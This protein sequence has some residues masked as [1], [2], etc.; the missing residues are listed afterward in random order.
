MPSVVN[1]VTPEG[2]TVAVPQEDL[3]AALRRGFRHEGGAD[4]GGRQMAA[5]ADA[6][7]G[8]LAGGVLGG[9]NAGLAGFARGATLGMSDVVARDLWTDAETLNA[10]REAHP[11]ISVTSEIAGNIAPALASGGLGAAGAAARATPAGY[12][13]GLGTRIAASGAEGSAARA[14]GTAAAGAAVEGSAQNLGSYISDVALGNKELSAEGALAAAGTGGLLGGAAGGFLAAGERGFIAAKKLIPKHVATEQAVRKAAGD[15]DGQLSQAFAAGDDAAAEGARQL[16]VYRLQN[17]DLDMAAQAKLQEQKLAKAQADAAAAEAKAALHQ[18]KL[19]TQAELDKIRLE[20]AKTPRTSR[21]GK[22]AKAAP[23]ESVADLPTARDYVSTGEVRVPPPP[24]GAPVD[25]TLDVGAIPLGPA[26]TRPGATIPADLESALA[27]SVA[28]LKAGEPIESLTAAARPSAIQPIHE[29][30]AEIDPQAAKM[31]KQVRAVEAARARAAAVHDEVLST[32]NPRD[33]AGALMKREGAARDAEIAAGTR[34]KVNDSLVE[35]SGDAAVKPGQSFESYVTQRTR[36][37]TT[38]LRNQLTDDELIAESVARPEFH[39]YGEMQNVGGGVPSGVPRKDLWHR[40]LTDQTKLD[41]LEITTLVRTAEGKIV[42]APRMATGEEVW[43]V[44]KARAKEMDD[45]TAKAIREKLGLGATSANHGAEGAAEITSTHRAVQSLAE[46]ERSV[47]DLAQTLGPAAPPA[48]AEIAAGHAAAV[49]EQARKASTRAAQALDDMPAS[50]ATPSAPV[51]AEPGKPLSLVE[52]HQNIRAAQ[53]V[54]DGKAAAASTV[55]LPGAGTMGKAG[56]GAKKSGLLGTLADLG[57][58]AEAAKFVGI[59]VPGMPNIDDI[60]VIGPLVGGYLKLKALGMGLKRFGVR[61]PFTAEARLAAGAAAGRTRMIDAMDGLLTLG[62]K[63]A[64]AARPVAAQ[65]GWRTAD[66][67]KSVLYDDGTKRKATDVPS[68]VRARS[69]E[70]M[71]AQANPAGVQATVRKA[72]ADVRDPDVIDAF[73]AQATKVIDYLAKHAPVAPPPS[74]LGTTKWAAS[75]SESERFARRVRAANDPVT[76]LD[77]I[78]T[79]RVTPE[80]A[81]TLREVYPQLY[82]E[83]QQR[84]MEQAPKIRETLSHANVVRLSVLFEAP[85]AP[86]LE[87]DNLRAIQAA[88]MPQAS[89]APPPGAPPMGG[90]MQPPPAGAP[91]LSKLYQTDAQRRG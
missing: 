3:E 83:A 12:F 7:R 71:A 25:A 87:P 80:G 18:Q 43:D 5:A 72:L 49:E 9:V 82:A 20:K 22:G 64:K 91:D 79:G 27:E 73:A 29:A 40:I 41:D 19:S 35:Y 34:S 86:S 38:R 67:L 28:R 24:S 31:V 45:S 13:A 88:G 58:A 47:A 54:N 15:V 48:A 37:R 32:L 68:M 23:A 42:S 84:L 1:M 90:G 65:A 44:I 21:P 69:E 6:E 53:A 59:N 14:I 60:P 17:A 46:Y 75:P 78:R 11:L 61:I 36:D 85:L 39:D 52:I 76:V 8:R 26:T 66:V 57:A 4:Y 30:M 81:E 33:Y 55:S 70:L 74:L 2:A 16:E 10:L 51:V 89:V 50:A 56:A 62:A 77:D 63:G